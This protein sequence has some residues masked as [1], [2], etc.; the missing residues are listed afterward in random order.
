SIRRAKLQSTLRV[1]SGPAM[2]ERELDA[3]SIEPPQ[4]GAQQR[5]GLERFR[6][7]APTRTDKRRLSQ[8]LAPRAQRI[9][10]KRL[11]G[12]CKPRRRLAISGQERGQ[13]LAVRELESAAA[14]PQE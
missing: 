6:K 10:R 5:R 13:R 2:A 7:H 11:D 9:G 4:P 3:R 12:R 8:S 14:G 1:P